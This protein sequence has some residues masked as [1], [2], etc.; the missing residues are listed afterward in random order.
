MY[1]INFNSPILIDTADGKCR[2]GLVLQKDPG[3]HG[4][5]GSLAVGSSCP[6]TA[7]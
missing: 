7:R 5:G 1:Q 4:G 2:I 6:L 3:D